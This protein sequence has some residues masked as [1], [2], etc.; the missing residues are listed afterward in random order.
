VSTYNTIA[1]VDYLVDTGSATNLFTPIPGSITPNTGISTTYLTTYYGGA[2][3]EFS[4]KMDH[5]VTLNGFIKI[6]APADITYDSNSVSCQNG[7]TSVNIG[8][9]SATTTVASI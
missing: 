2:I 6:T 5:D 3:Y 7:L 1:G 9:C 8:T 4:F